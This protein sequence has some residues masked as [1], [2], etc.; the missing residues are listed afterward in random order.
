MQKTR[1]VVTTTVIYDESGDHPEF[2]VFPGTILN[3]H[4]DEGDY[5]I[6]SRQDDN[7]SDVLFPVEKNR[8]MEVYKSCRYGRVT[9]SS[10]E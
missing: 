2:V 4:S 3:I 8:G 1:R 10:T 6:C 5:W 7:L 9:A